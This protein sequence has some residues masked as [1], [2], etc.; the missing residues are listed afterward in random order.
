MDLLAFEHDRSFILDALRRG[1][2]D[3]L[4][5]MGEAME[6]TFFR[7]LM[8]RQILQ[9]LA[10]SYPTRARNKKSLSGSIWPVRSA[11]NCKARKVIMLFHAYCARAVSSMP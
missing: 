4:E 3:Y 6:A 5:H 7:Q 11:S 10:D 9:R 2:I 8:N 1:E